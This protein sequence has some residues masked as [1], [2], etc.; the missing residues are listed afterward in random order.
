[1]SK[2]KILGFLRT[3]GPS[4]PASISKEVGQNSLIVSSIL[5]ELSSEGVV[6]I[7]NVKFGSSPF[8]Y[9]PEH[10]NRLELLSKYL[11]EKDQRTYNLLREQKVVRDSE[12]DPFFKVSIQSIKDFSV[13]IKVNSQGSVETY[14]RY[15]L[16]SHDEAIQIIKQRYFTSKGPDKHEVKESVSSTSNVEINK[17][18]MDN[19][20]NSYNNNHNKNNLPQNNQGNIPSS[21]H[22]LNKQGSIKK[23]IDGITRQLDNKKEP[24]HKFTPSVSQNSMQQTKQISQKP[25]HGQSSLILDKLQK[26][27][28]VQKKIVSTEENIGQVVIP[29]EEFMIEINKVFSQRGIIVVLHEIVRKNTEY[30]MVV[31]VP[32]PIG[33]LNF[34]CKAK[35]KKKINDGD[36]SSAYFK[37]QNKNLPVL[38]IT[39]GKLTKKAEEMVKEFKNNFTV[40]SL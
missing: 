16:I 15:Y 14:W 38:F 6:K 12:L 40:M 7:T 29:D 36:I 18:T 11:G 30:D 1:M 3:K 33:S 27:N 26:S 32:S 23:E 4:V 19:N 13:P 37:G 8:Y 22:D 39:S 5:S 28:D 9:L 17:N 25:G 34:Y 35:S 2:D 24:E 21:N 31:K 10:R 20:I